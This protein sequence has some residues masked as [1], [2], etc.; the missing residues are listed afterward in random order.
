MSSAP[1]DPVGGDRVQVKPDAQ[2]EG[3]RFLCLKA[4][5][6]MPP[7]G[8]SAGERRGPSYVSGDLFSCPAD[9]ALA[10]CI[11]EDCRM[12]AGVAAAFR[13]R[14]GG[15]AELK[16]Q[17]ESAAFLSNGPKDVSLNSHANICVQPQ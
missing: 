2:G 6:T 12:G 9:E 5:V 13:R 3:G 1:R 15:V 4:G 10:H 17:S 16:G 11:S 14:F 7:L 8:Q